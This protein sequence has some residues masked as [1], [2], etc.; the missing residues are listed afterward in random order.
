MR[1]HFATN[2]YFI[3]EQKTKKKLNNKK[4]TEHLKG[5]KIKFEMS[6]S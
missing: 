1:K 6:E 4:R 3:L 2:L 5:E